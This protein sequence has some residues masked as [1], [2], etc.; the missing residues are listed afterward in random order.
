MNWKPL[1]EPPTESGTYLIGHRGVQKVVKFL[2]RSPD[3]AVGTNTRY[4]W[5]YD[6]RNFKATHW[7]E[8]G[9]VPDVP[10]PRASFNDFHRGDIIRVT[11]DCNA[12]IFEQ[13]SYQTVVP[14]RW[15]PFK[16]NVRRRVTND[17]C[18]GFVPVKAGTRGA[19]MRIQQFVGNCWKDDVTGL[20]LNEET[21]RVWV[22][23]N[24]SGREVVFYNQ[25][26]YNFVKDDSEVT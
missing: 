12:A 19:I 10:E 1:T 24:D 5:Q 22:V 7:C 2:V 15:G 17:K 26:G 16:W 25:I 3:C 4:G 23:L 9:A 20:L 18:K 13:K 21:W 8:I 6:P 14:V 11:M